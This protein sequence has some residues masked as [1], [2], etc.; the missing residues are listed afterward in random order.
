MKMWRVA[1]IT[2]SLPIFRSSMFIYNTW[3][4]EGSNSIIKLNHPVNIQNILKLS[5]WIS[6]PRK[7]LLLIASL[8]KPCRGLVQVAE[9][10]RVGG[11]RGVSLDR[12]L[13]ATQVQYYSLTLLKAFIYKW[14]SGTKC[15]RS[16]AMDYHQY[17]PVLYTGGSCWYSYLLQKHD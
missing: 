12:K 9:N 5:L 14:V 4:S 2:S 1:E 10:Q 15:W 3:I 16:L 8:L 17:H 11:G 6:V 7:A 13:Y